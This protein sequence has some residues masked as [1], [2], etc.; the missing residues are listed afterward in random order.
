MAGETQYEL[1]QLAQRKGKQRDATLA[2]ILATAALIDDLARLYLIAIQTRIEE[3]GDTLVP[4]FNA[5]LTDD[6]LKWVESAIDAKVAGAVIGASTALATYFRRLESWQLS[7]WVRTVLAATDV[8]L[9]PLLTSSEA[10][11]IV[12]AAVNTNAALLK[13]VSDNLKVRLDTILWDAVNKRRF[14]QIGMGPMVVPPN[15]LPVGS[16]SFATEFVA[17]INKAAEIAIRRAK[18][19]AADQVHSV[20]ADLNQ[21]RQRQAGVTEYVWNHTPQA[22]PRHWHVAR[23]GKVYSWSKPPYDG[24]PGTLPFCKCTA[25]AYVRIRPLVTTPK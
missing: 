12:Q 24:P 13:G 1:A 6:Q 25:R 21:Y 9:A 8:D 4:A 14:A 23:H 10:S 20:V 2:A 5:G 11:G 3:T 22:N 18:N 19:T 16:A 17:E 15:G 7:F